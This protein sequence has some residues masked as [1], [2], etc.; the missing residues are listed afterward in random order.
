VSTDRGTGTIIGALSAAVGL[1]AAELV[2]GAVPTGRSPVVAVADRVIRLGPPSWERRLIDLLGTNDK[3]FLVAVI[4]VATLV[5]GILAGHWAA[6]R[7][8]AAWVVVAGAAV[9]GVLSA[10]AEEDSSWVHALPP[11]VGAL[12]AIVTLVLLTRA[13]GDGTDAPLVP[14]AAGR[15]LLLAGGAAGAVAAIT[16]AGGRL[17]QGRV[18]ASASRQAVALPKPAVALPPIPTG[19]SLHVP[20]LSPYVTPNKDFYRID[21]SLVVPQVETKG[22]TLRVDGMVDTPMTITYEQLLARPMVEA[23]V[24]LM[25]VSNQIGGPLIGNA[26]WLGVPLKDLLDEVGVSP[27]ADQLVGRAVDGFT[28]GSPLKAVLDGRD[29]IVAVGMNGEPLPLRHG[30]P[31]RLVVGG[32]YGYVSATKWLSRIE[33]TRFDAYDPYWI[34]RGWSR[35]GPV[36]VGAR[37]DT[38]GGKT[39][40][41]P[42]P[43]AGVAWAQGRGVDRVEARI[44]DGSWH[45]AVLGDAVGDDTWRQW[46]YD[47][48]ATAGKHT[49][50]V[51]ATTSDGEVQTGEQADVF[52]DGATGWHTVTVRID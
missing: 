25:C 7:P 9:V 24:T 2:A 12:A 52:P 36:K 45:D 23:D 13:T 21:V 40:A 11:V 34:E 10:L 37:I 6:T 35:Q 5:L 26:R 42:I 22:W 3:P 14:E 16:G 47:W 18:D 44:D 49:I 19:A 50:A 29:A 28:T 48:D 33:I 4:L 31:A 17:L 41:G 51:R 8:T 38:L 43:V 1:G 39:T 15:R 46:R 32:L 20:G 27:K 30:F